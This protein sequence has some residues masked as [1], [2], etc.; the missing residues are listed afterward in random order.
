MA[1]QWGE[2]K[3]ANNMV[4]AHFI[5]KERA[6]KEDAVLESTAEISLE[7]RMARTPS[8]GRTTSLFK[9]DLS[10]GEQAEF[11]KKINNRLQPEQASPSQEVNK[12]P[13]SHKEVPKEK[14]TDRA[15]VATQE[16]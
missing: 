14:S 3:P 11:M 7:E 10:A 6:V 12:L 1:E 13:I 4:N 15:Q 2:M 5:A 8:S 9:R 16:R